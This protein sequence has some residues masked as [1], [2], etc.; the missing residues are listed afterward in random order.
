M[1]LSWIHIYIYMYIYAYVYTLYNYKNT[2]AYICADQTYV[3]ACSDSWLNQQLWDKNIPDLLYVNL[4]KY[5]TH[6]HM[7]IQIRQALGPKACGILSSALA[8]A[9]GVLIVL[10]PWL[11]G[12]TRRRLA[13]NIV[14]PIVIKRRLK[15]IKIDSIAAG[16]PSVAADTAWALYTWVGTER[17]FRCT[18]V[19]RERF[20]HP[21]KVSHNKRC[22]PNM[23]IKPM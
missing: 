10:L 7:D 3:N 21:H 20:W 13:S 6:M 17:R 8:I 15:S 19:G 16:L 4:N 2:C 14:Q 1:S 12:S 23:F 9:I 11:K 18:G 5:T 22:Q